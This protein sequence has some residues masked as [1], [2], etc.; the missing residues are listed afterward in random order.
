MVSNLLG[1]FES[2]TNL[3]TMV[4]ADCSA[5]EVHGFLCGHLCTGIR[6]HESWLRHA[7]GLLD[8][9]TL[10][11]DIKSTF[12]E[13]FDATEMQINTA[14]FDFQLLLPDDDEEV[15]VRV[16][17][18]GQWCQGFLT[19]FGMGCSD[20][21]AHK[22]SD[23]VKSALADFVAISQ[24]NYDDVDEDDPTEA[25]YTEVMEYVRMA[26]LSIAMECRDQSAPPAQNLLH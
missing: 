12:V 11:S 21:R 15:R 2:V 16:E 22:M 23:D 24:V 7:Q 25:D 5:A 14:N 19:C 9:G 1:S 8:V 3:L 4:G 10:N 20:E 17:A 6:T 18:I 26:V 13:L